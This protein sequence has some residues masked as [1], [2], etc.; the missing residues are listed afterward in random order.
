RLSFTRAMATEA[1]TT[2]SQGGRIRG[3]IV[4]GEVAA[5]VL[6]LFGAGLLVRTLIAVERGDRGY[7]ADRVLSMMV[8]PLDERYPTPD[9]LVR[10]FDDVE[11]EVLAIPGIRRAGWT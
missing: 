5:A 3:A 11:R 10:F 1:R 4:I 2:T 8:D 9:A 6:L 7:S